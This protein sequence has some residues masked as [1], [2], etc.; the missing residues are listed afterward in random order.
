MSATLA[1]LRSAGVD[2]K[3]GWMTAA[4]LELYRRLLSEQV[5]KRGRR[6]NLGGLNL[7]PVLLT[8]HS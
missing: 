3:T 5:A 1:W 7:Y 4:R 2:P 6:R 8:P